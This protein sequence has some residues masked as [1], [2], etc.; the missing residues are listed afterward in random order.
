LVFQQWA[1]PKKITVGRSEA[2]PPSDTFSPRIGKLADE[3]SVNDRSGARKRFDA[4]PGLEGATPGGDS[5][6]FP[7]AKS[8]ETAVSP[9]KTAGRTARSTL[10]P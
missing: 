4:P 3:S 5:A 8:R 2:M 7:P 1:V 9:R 6:R 10:M